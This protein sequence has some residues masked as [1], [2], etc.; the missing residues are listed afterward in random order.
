MKRLCIASKIHPSNNFIDNYE[1]VRNALK[2]HRIKWIEPDNLHITL[3]FLGPV[4]EERIPDIIGKLEEV[5]FV[6]Y[7]VTL[8][9]LGIFGSKYAP[10]VIWT[11]VNDRGETN[12]LANQII[13]KM[14]AVGFPRDRQ[15]FVPHLTLGR[16]KH[17]NGTRYFFKKFNSV[18]D[19]FFQEDNIQD[20][21]LY[22]SILK[23]DGP[24]YRVLRRFPVRK[25]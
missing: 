11:K 6:P 22:E 18:K 12:L 2:A 3:K 16:I 19:M 9:D 1:T 5:R 4:A 17:T 14:E 25:I 15:N 8:K 10:R 21:Y 23:K 24:E 7:P 20:F 13:D